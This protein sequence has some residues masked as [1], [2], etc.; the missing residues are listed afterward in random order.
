MSAIDR[1]RG[2]NCCLMAQ[3]N[4][5]ICPTMIS[6]QHLHLMAR[7]S[8][9]SIL[10]RPGA[11]GLPQDIELIIFELLNLVLSQHSPDHHQHPSLRREL[12]FRFWPPAALPALPVS[13]D[14][15]SKQ[16]KLQDSLKICRV[17]S[18]FITSC[19]GAQYLRDMLRYCVH[20]NSLLNTNIFSHWEQIHAE[21]VWEREVLRD[22]MSGPD[23][24][25][26]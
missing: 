16:F 2:C 20:H 21:T 23:G 10:L 1:S 19:C 22:V 5:T 13:A 15:D 9:V 25:G 18:V 11:R 3:E 17:H 14:L 24:N 12:W 4:W 6:T 8:L 7:I 26:L